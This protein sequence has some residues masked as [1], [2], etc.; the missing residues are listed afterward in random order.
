MYLPATSRP[1]P[2]PPRR[3]CRRRMRCRPGGSSAASAPPSPRTPALRMRCAPRRDPVAQPLPRRRAMCKTGCRKPWRAPCA[4]ARSPRTRRRRAFEARK[5][6]GLTPRATLVMA[7]SEATKPHPWRRAAPAAEMAS[8]T[9]AMTVPLT[10]RAC[11]CGVGSKA[12][13]RSA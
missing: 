5:G 7:R 3:A 9:P 1:N 13:R 4:P 11:L 6:A 12:R 2:G 10:P 8:L